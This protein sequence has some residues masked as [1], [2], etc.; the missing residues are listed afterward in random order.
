MQQLHFLEESLEG[1][2]IGLCAIDLTLKFLKINT[3]AAETLGLPRPPEPGEDVPEV[4]LQHDKKGVVHSIQKVISSGKTLFYDELSE[5]QQKF[6]KYKIS[7]EG[8]WILMIISKKSCA[9][10]QVKRD[11]VFREVSK[12]AKIGYWE[13]DLAQNNLYW[14]QEVYNLYE[15]GHEELKPTLE[16]Y[17]TFVVSEDREDCKAAFSRHI[18]FNEEFNSIHRI[19][20]PGGKIKYMH[21]RC[22]TL[23]D[24][25]GN[26]IKSLGVVADVTELKSTEDA[27]A[28]REKEYRYIFETMAQG[29]VYQRATGEIF[30]VN[31]AAEAMLGLSLDQMQGRTSVD[32]RWKALKGDGSDYPRNEHPAMVSIQTG[33]PVKNVEMGVYNPI[34]DDYTWI[35]VSAEPQFRPGE[36]TPFQ[37]YTSFTDITQIKAVQR[38][39]EKQNTLL[40]LLTRFSSSYINL[41]VD[42]IDDMINNSMEELG[43]FIGLD[44]FYLFEYDEGVHFCSNTHEWCA[45]GISPQIHELQNISMDYFEFWKSSHIKGETVFIPDVLALPEGDGAREVLEPQQIKSL[46]AVPIMDGK[47][48]IGFTGFDS[49]KKHHNY[50]ESEEKLLSVFAEMLVN[51]KKRKK[52]EEELKANKLFLQD[53]IEYSGSLIV[54][55][56][57]NG[58]YLLVNKK[59]EQIT[60]ISRDKVLGKRDEEIFPVEIATEYIKNDKEVL[61]H[62]QMIEVEETH[63]GPNGR[64]YFLSTKF[65]VKD[66]AGSANGIC[67]MFTEITQ[68]KET[69]IALEKSESNLKSVIENSLESI[70]LTNTKHEIVYANEIFIKEF[71]QTFGVELAP[72]V[73]KLESLPKAMHDIWQERYKKVFAG[74]ILTFE[75]KLEI[76]GHIIYIEVSARPVYV[77]GKVIAASFFGRNITEKK[78]A[79]DKLRRNEQFLSSI[80]QTQ[81]EMI[82][83]FLPDT[84]LIFVNKA[85]CDT[86]QTTK[87]KLIGKQFMDL[88]QPEDREWLSSKL[89]SINPNTPSVS[90]ELRTILPDGQVC[91]QEWTDTAI[92]NEKNEAVEYQ[93]TGRDITLQKSAIKKMNDALAR[94]KALLDAIPD[95]MLV[96]D[97]E[98]KI[99]DF[100]HKE[101]NA[102]YTHPRNFVGK[103]VTEVMPSSVATIAK[104]CIN[105]VLMYGH[106]EFATYDLMIDGVQKHFEVRFVKYIENEVLA[107][108]RDISDTIAYIDAIESQNKILKE[109]A[110]TQSHVVRAPL[111]RMM[112]LIMMLNRENYGGMTLD[113]IIESISKSADELNAI[114]CKIAEKTYEVKI[115]IDKNKYI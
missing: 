42:Q 17:F 15:C 32:P 40:E 104:S 64:R 24:A 10:H 8:E 26:A 65:P 38:E 76:E 50:T 30:K 89:A 69:L 31:P 91:W 6:V 29:I 73:N 103:K 60:G 61:Q 72:G 90:Y 83:R 110:W 7:H 48:C 39:L 18:Q 20:T 14:S 97:P 101:T 11:F 36:D 84:T 113:F 111:S 68:I 114:I 58:R 75:D 92:F 47:T 107:I 96:F 4:L 98:T 99:I 55:K 67:G 115:D 81:E 66:N 77:E 51:V 80:V 62:S 102:Y 33:K 94:H 49:V 22:M 95:L 54:R 105:Q 79:E 112:S 21:A 70:W 1:L 100:H 3:I 35:L 78:L 44:R 16:G 109:I 53:I 63:P 82:C 27:L 56:D 52:A 28:E 57:L 85:Y 23:H 93:S 108:V 45:E 59:W 25:A 37:V 9:D 87:E 88:V 2:D 74:E 12:L 46:V 34:K 13:Y 43:R 41:P 5:A 19:Q 106:Q 86:Y 71:Q